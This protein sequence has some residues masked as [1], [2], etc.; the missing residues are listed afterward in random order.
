MF[1]P[2]NEDAIMS[3]IRKL[4]ISMGIWGNTNLRDRFDPKGSKNNVAVG[5]LY[6]RSSIHKGRKRN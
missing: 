5:G 4:K 3:R 1:S 2:N 6:G